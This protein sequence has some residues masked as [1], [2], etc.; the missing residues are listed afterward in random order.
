MSS[1]DLFLDCC[2]HPTL[3]RPSNLSVWVTVHFSFLFRLFAW[4][5]PSSFPHF[6]LIY[7][8]ISLVVCVGFFG[9]SNIFAHRPRCFF[10]YGYVLV[11]LFN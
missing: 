6:A 10:L 7:F 3:F 4:I 11:I 8:L 5:E 9:S 2:S 1:D